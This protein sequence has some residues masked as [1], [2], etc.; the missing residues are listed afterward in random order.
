MKMFKQPKRL[1]TDKRERRD[2][3]F[4]PVFTGQIIPK[5]IYVE[6][7]SYKKASEALQ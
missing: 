5:E 1:K 3:T 2:Y 4:Y 6:K 7:K